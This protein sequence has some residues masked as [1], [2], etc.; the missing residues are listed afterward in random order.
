MMTNRSTIE[1]DMHVERQMCGPVIRYDAG[2]E[3]RVQ[4]VHGQAAQTREQVQAA[5]TRLLA[6]IRDVEETA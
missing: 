3:F 6:Q 5:V 1:Q 2:I 4:W